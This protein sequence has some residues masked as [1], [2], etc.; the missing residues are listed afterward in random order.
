[1]EK[2]SDIQKNIEAKKRHFLRERSYI[3]EQLIEYL[4]SDLGF[5]SP[6]ADERDDTFLD[7]AAQSISICCTLIRSIHESSYRHFDLTHGIKKFKTPPEYWR[8]VPMPSVSSRTFPKGTNLENELEKHLSYIQIKKKGF[9]KVLQE[10][11]VLQRFNENC[12][13]Y[14]DEI[15]NIDK[16]VSL[17]LVETNEIDESLSLVEGKTNFGDLDV[18]IIVHLDILKNELSAKGD[19]EETT[20]SGNNEM[21]EIRIIW[22][23]VSEVRITWDSNL[24]KVTEDISFADSKSILYYVA[25]RFESPYELSYFALADVLSLIR[26][27]GA[28]IEKALYKDDFKAFFYIRSIFVPT[29]KLSSGISINPLQCLDKT[30]EKAVNASEV[31]LKHC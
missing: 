26:N 14:V 10:I 8:N 16:H 29:M 21:G 6:S 13:D 9:D 28:S 30:F 11:K 19:T 4:N 24:V 2:T 22:E 5:C 1:M 27:G 7:N 17:K 12:F 3:N 20:S 15:S 23:S 25:E 18:E 31:I